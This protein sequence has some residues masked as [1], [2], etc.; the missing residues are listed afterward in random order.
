MTI[1][2]PI[3]LENK[4]QEM[5]LHYHILSRTS[6]T[7]TSRTKTKEF[8]LKRQVPTSLTKYLNK[9]NNTLR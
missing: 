3:L 1:D 7:M 4:Y 9:I 2:F 5:S 6:C 8:D